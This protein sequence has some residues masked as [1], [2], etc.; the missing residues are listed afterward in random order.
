MKKKYKILTLD[1]WDTIIRRKCHPD[2]IKVCTAKYLYLIAFDDIKD[3]CHDITFLTSARIEAEREL[4]QRNQKLGN[5]D[6][7]II[8]DVLELWCKKVFVE[9]SKV[10][11]VLIKQLYDFE[12]KTEIKNAYLDPTIVDLLS[13]YEYEMV[14]CISDFY[15][16]KEFILS[17]LE[18]VGF[19]VKLDF[20]YI[21][22]EYG[23][24]KRSGRLFSQV[25]KDLAVE[26]GEQMHIGDN[27]FSD[28]EI[29]ENMGIHTLHYVP[30]AEYNRKQERE[31]NF[32]LGKTDVLKKDNI[33][34]QASVGISI[35]FYGFVSWIIESCVRKHIDKIYFFTR[36]GEF[37][38]RIYDEIVKTC[39]ANMNFPQSYLL[40]VSR[41]ATFGPSI[42][43]VTLSEMMR[44][45]NQYS[46]QSMH[47]FFASLGFRNEKG[48]Q[49]YLEKYNIPENEVIIYPWLDNRVQEMFQN[50]EFIA[51][52]ED[53]IKKQRITLESYCLQKDLK[54]GSQEQIAIV[55]IGWRGTIQDNLCYLYPDYHICGFYVGL[56]DFLNKQP[57]NSEK[58]GYLEKCTYKDALLKIST[59][60]E[61]IC[62]SPNGSTVFYKKEGE[63]TVAVRKIEE[64]E[65]RI[66]YHYT[67]MLQDNIINDINSFSKMNQKYRMMSDSY[68]QEAYMSLKKFVF[69]PSQR[70]VNAYFGL[71]H[72]EEFG[73]GT[74]VDK[75]TR[76]RPLLIC[77]ALFKKE[78][79]NELKEFL[80]ETTWPQG[81]LTKY[82]LYPALFVYNYLLQRYYK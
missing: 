80:S 20:V 79:R 2:E 43:E 56:V 16:G 9:S 57:Y 30:E 64:S 44:I 22:C 82:F 23:V 8:N 76:F 35:F 52:V 53:E 32:S 38:K 68:L 15:A 40:E 54:K 1:V 55:D 58:Y 45:W 48:V 71:I 69:Y 3:N 17:L 25:Q 51:F 47:A 49:L 14:G 27:I 31:K 34:K 61:M 65:D 50:Q 73:V 72:N 63:S 26:E 77:Q 18:A 42:R 41:I 62:N 13:N 10:N 36:E 33:F 6:E 28:V 46:I 75:R 70:C 81:Y 37:Y 60:F 21:S 19:P 4:G 78:K 66:Y 5:D 67:K 39:D 59:P 74:Y 11:Q 7:Y 12:L 24:N 29:P